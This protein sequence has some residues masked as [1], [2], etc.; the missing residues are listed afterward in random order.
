MSATFLFATLYFVSIVLSSIINDCPLL[1]HICA[2]TTY[3]AGF[4]LVCTH[5]VFIMC[6]NWMG[7]TL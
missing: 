5:P 6:D 4:L 7:A 1:L 2:K 3:T